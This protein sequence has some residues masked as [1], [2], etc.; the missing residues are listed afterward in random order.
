MPPPVEYSVFRESRNGQL[1]VG[2]GSS[3]ITGNPSPTYGDP[4]FRG[5]TWEEYEVVTKS[6]AKFLDVTLATSSLG[7]IDMDLEMRDEQ[8]N[9]VASATT[10]FANEHFT[11]DVQPNARYFIRVLGWRNGPAQYTL[12][13]D[14][15]LP[16]GSPNEN[17]GR[18]TIG[19]SGGSSSGGGSGSGLTRLV[20]FTVNP[21][22]KKVTFTLL[23]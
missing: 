5:I 14:Q 20:R 3:Y 17:A 19:G 22:L 7:A 9:L 15:L 18:T 23:R 12:T 13:T 21:L 2:E 10:E 8:G 6:D 16:A 1:I 11:I 4:A